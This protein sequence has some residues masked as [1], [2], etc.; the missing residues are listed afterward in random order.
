MDARTG[1][2]GIS[3]AVL[4][5]LGLALAGNVGASAPSETV[6]AEVIAEGTVYFPEGTF[7]WRAFEETL[8][9]G[10]SEQSPEPFSIVA[11]TDGAIGVGDASFPLPAGTATMIEVEP[12]PILSSADGATY[13][14]LQIYNEANSEPEFA[15]GSA[16][17]VEGVPHDAQL[18]QALLDEGQATVIDSGDL[19]ALVFVVGG[20]AEVTTENAAE[21]VVVGAGESDT[22]EGEVTITAVDGGAT[23]VAAVLTST[24]APEVE[25]GPASGPAPTASGPRPEY[26]EVTMS[27]QVQSA[28]APGETVTATVVIEPPGYP[29]VQSEVH[30]LAE[31]SDFQ[32]GANDCYFDDYQVVDVDPE[33]RTT[34]DFVVTMGTRPGGCS[35]SASSGSQFV[36][37]SATEVEVTVGGPSGASGAANPG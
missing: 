16:F 20:T 29:D 15:T 10:E 5:S 26:L 33:E 18:Q 2:V 9:A 28:A 34:V 23:V 14:V 8:E 1:P 35:I 27:I 6:P 32:T 4:A 17:D 3:V 25:P 12:R 37:G 31:P 11:V 24:A 22:F 7:H 30:L 36:F 19:P 21:P 13:W